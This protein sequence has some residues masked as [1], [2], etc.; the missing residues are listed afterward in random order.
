[1]TESVSQS[2]RSIKALTNACLRRRGSDLEGLSGRSGSLHT[3]YDEAG[4]A[5]SKHNHVLCAIVKAKMLSLVRVLPAAQPAP[6]YFVPSQCSAWLVDLLD[7]VRRHRR[8][9][10]LGQYVCNIPSFRRTQAHIDNIFAVALSP[11][12]FDSLY[13]SLFGSKS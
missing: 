13:S 8:R 12:K 1:M 5:A 3:L 9:M 7:V 4:A 11:W 2:P 6:Q 10:C